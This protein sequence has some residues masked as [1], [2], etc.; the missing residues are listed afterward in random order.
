[1]NRYELMRYERGLTRARVARE[2]GVS[3]TT[4]IGLEDGSVAKPSA[5]TA[6]ALARVY[7]MTVAQL[8]GVDEPQTEA[9]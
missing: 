1:M 7:G 6:A 9:A 2:S 5:P 3:V 4:I 8:L